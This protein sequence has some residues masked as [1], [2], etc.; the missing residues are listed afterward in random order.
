MRPGGVAA[1]LAGRGRPRAVVHEFHGH[2]LAEYFDPTRERLYRLA[3][4]AL[5]RSSGA[6]V[7]VS[8]EVRD[9]LVRLGVAPPEKIHVI[10][11][12]FDL[13]RRLDRQRPARAPP[14]RGTGSASR[15]TRS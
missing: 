15:K 6:L 12:G 4:R 13:D 11:Y 8:D 7:A 1:L 2:V 9:D 3:E 14:A 10:A 5:A